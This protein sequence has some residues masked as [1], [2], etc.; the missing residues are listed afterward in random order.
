MINKIKS[1]FLG[2]ET[3]SHLFKTF[4]VYGF[5]SLSIII[6][7]I[8]IA[9]LYG[10]VELGIFTFFF[11]LVSL[12]F[13]FT[14]FGI[15]EA[16]TQKII[17]NSDQTKHYL[18]K[19]I[20]AI[21][22]PTIIFLVTS[23]MI[24]SKTSLSPNIQHFNWAFIVYIVAYTLHYFTYSI[25]RGQKKFVTASIFSLIN[26]IS[27]I[28]LIIILATT[29][30][31]F[32]VVLFS[33]S[34][35]L[36][37]ATLAS[38][39]FIK[40]KKNAIKNLPESNKV[41]LLLAFSLFLTQ[42]S[43]YSLRFV[44]VITI[45]LLVDF[46]SLGL[47]SAYGSITNVIRLLGYVFPMVVIPMAAVSSFKIKQSFKKLLWLLLPFSS[48]VL[49]STYFLVP[50]LYG[51]EYQATY[52]PVVLVISSTLLIIYSYFNSIFVGENKYSSFYIKIIFIDFLISLVINTLLNIFFI[53]RMGI[54]GA[55]I[56]TAITIVIKIILNI[57]GIKKLRIKNKS[58][59]I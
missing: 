41:F 32:I 59:N 50:F 55:P 6:I 34:V 49:A 35:A 3:R 21:I 28:I 47:Y 20:F 25:M 57:Y 31:K 24:V 46:A 54:I 8:L 23:T 17:R 4:F 15:P 39:P 19:A 27:V 37:I 18:K 33:F 29:P 13:L 30:T 38:L 44:D 11:S 12:V 5:I 45:E 42:V 36:I 48:I 22:P 58:Q 1:I 7:K 43:F 40:I 14:S 52:L 2:G 56:A 9:R 51:N 53:Q 26:R 16:L 10:Q